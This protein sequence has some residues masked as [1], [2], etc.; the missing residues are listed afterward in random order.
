MVQWHDFTSSSG[1]FKKINWKHSLVSACIA[2]FLFC[3][4]AFIYIQKANYTVSWVLYLGSL[5]Y[6][7]TIATV[8]VIDNNNRGG[9]ESTIAMIFASL[10][11]TIAGIILSVV[12]CLIL[13]S[14]LDH[15]SI[16]FGRAARTM[17]E[18]PPA[19]IQGKTGGLVFRTMF[20]AV[21][22]NFFGGTFAGV[23][24]P[25]YSKQ[26]QTIDDKAPTPLEKHQHITA[27]GK[28]K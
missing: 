13:L 9:N 1:M 23:T 12:V 10:V 27:E 17:T 11:I 25:F 20:A 24:I 15:G 22:L 16:G 6:F 8:T 2:S 19:S 14:V 4:C 21:V 18:N 5:L 3:T 7:F 28:L 26:N